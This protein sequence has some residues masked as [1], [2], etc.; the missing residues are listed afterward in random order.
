MEVFCPKLLNLCFCGK[1]V[2]KLFYF[3]VLVFHDAGVAY[4]VTVKTGVTKSSGTDAKVNNYEL[5]NY[6]YYN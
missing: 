6:N 3:I 4:K 1:Y 2:L 5:I